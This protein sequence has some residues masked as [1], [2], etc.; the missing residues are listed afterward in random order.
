VIRYESLKNKMQENFLTRRE[1]LKFAG[2]FV[3]S[4]AGFLDTDKRVRAQESS[5]VIS[6]ERLRDEFGITILDLPQKRYPENYVELNFAES[7]INTEFFRVLKEDSMKLTIV[8]INDE[9]VN[10]QAL[11]NTQSQALAGNQEVLEIIEEQIDFVRNE[12]RITIEQLK[13]SVQAVYNKELLSLE[14]RMQKGFISQDEFS[15]LS[16]A[17]RYQYMPYLIEGENITDDMVD[18]YKGA[19]LG[20]T[21][22]VEIF[23]GNSTELLIFLAVRNPKKTKT[24]KSGDVVLNVPTPGA[25]INIQPHPYQSYPSADSLGYVYNGENRNGIKIKTSGIL[26]RHE[27]AH[28]MGIGPE[29]EADRYVLF[30]ILKA[31]ELYQNNDPRGYW[32]IFETPKGKTYTAR[33]LGNLQC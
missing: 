3:G 29:G 28:A 12:N 27:M 11:D 1:F 8:L 30:E 18:E 32:I 19:I 20:L 31:Q 13:D 2:L 10:I 26:L 15:V 17:L 14:E 25:D 4:A 33:P 22:M 5:V 7:A 23:E 9:K 21:A 16:R 6:R 24:F